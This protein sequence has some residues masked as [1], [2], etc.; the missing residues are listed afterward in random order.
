M[1]YC[2]K[3][4]GYNVKLEEHFALRFNGF[5]VVIAGIAF[6]VMEETLLVMIDIPL[7]D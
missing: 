6:W 4:Q 3:I 5:H 1:H 7:H 2:K